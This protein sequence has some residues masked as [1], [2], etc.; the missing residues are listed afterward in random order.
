M[1]YGLHLKRWGRAMVKMMKES[2]SFPL[3]LG[4][5]FHFLK[6]MRSECENEK[7]THPLIQKKDQIYQKSPYFP[8]LH[9]FYAAN[10]D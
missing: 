5:S 9:E 10:V 7:A 3:K 1:D 2:S 6:K 8:I 4:E